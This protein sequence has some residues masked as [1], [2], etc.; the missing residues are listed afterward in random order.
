MDYAQIYGQLMAQMQN[1]AN[2]IQM[3]ILKSFQLQT[4]TY[5][6]DVTNIYLAFIN[7]PLHC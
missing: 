2:S 4:G 5:I 3:Q 7:G 6:N 1:K